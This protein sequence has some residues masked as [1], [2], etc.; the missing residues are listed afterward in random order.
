MHITSETLERALTHRSFSYENG[1]VPTNERLEFLGDAILGFVVADHLFGAYPD[2]AE[3]DLA[4]RRASVVSTRALAHV[5]RELGV[6]QYIRLGAGERATGGADKDSILADTFEA[7]LGSVYVDHGSVAAAGLVHRHII[8]LLADERVA[9]EGTDFKTI[10][11][12]AASRHD[13]GEVRYDIVGQGPAHA[14]RFEATLWVGQRAYRSAVASSKKQAE[15][16]A[17]AASWPDMEASLPTST[18]S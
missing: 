7:L 12:E 9:R 6:G 8:P 18:P 10:V 5:A 3:G 11:A 1:N 17:A 14:P 2:L 13:L 15:R 16:D 4:R